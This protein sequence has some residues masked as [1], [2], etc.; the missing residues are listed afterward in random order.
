MS[1]QIRILAFTANDLVGLGICAALGNDPT[2]DFV[3][4]SIEQIQQLSLLYKQHQPTV[5]LVVIPPT[6]PLVYHQVF[7]FHQ[8][9]SILR[10]VL[11]VS[12]Y[13]TTYME[14]LLQLSA[15]A[16][17]FT[18]DAPHMLCTAVHTVGFGNS[19][20]SNVA[21][22]R[23]HADQQ[24]AKLQ[25]QRNTLLQ[26]LTN[27]E[28]EVLTL[29]AQGF[30]NEEIAQQLHVSGRTVRF[31]IHNTYEKLNFVSYREMIT[32]AVQSGLH[33]NVE[34]QCNH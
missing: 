25:N 22:Q 23:F 34:L 15:G 8:W 33:K 13:E 4:S 19:W 14:L 28:L 21:M 16:L 20:F 30:T 11:V 31:H 3:Q 6:S 2:I 17:V 18:T 10:V 26:R 24:H 32:W 5:L 7:A 9:E 27:R 1:Q 12:Q 29:L